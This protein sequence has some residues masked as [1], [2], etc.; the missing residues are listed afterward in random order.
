[1]V[2]LSE[3]TRII[4][5]LQQPEAYSH[6]IK[7]IKK[8]ITAVSVVFLTGEL[9]YKF[10]KPMNLGF[11]DFS[12]L[13]KRKDQCE[14]EI[15]YNSLISPSLYLGLATINQDEAGK[16]QINGSGK[17]I[18]YA[19]KM[20]QMNPDATIN[21][22][23]KKNK[24]TTN[25]ILKLAKTIHDFH[26]KASDDE[27]T[28][29]FGTLES[30]KFNWEENFQQTE[31]YK[32]FLIP[33]KTFSNIHHTVNLFLEKNKNLINQRVVKNKIKHCHGDFHSSNVFIHRGK[34][35]VF[36]GIVFNKRFPCSDIIAEIAF[37]AMDLE[38]HHQKELAATFINEYHRLS[39]DHD[40][41]KL[42]DF[43]KCYRAYIRGKIAC[44]TCDDQNL[45]AEEKEQTK[46]TAQE[47][48][49]L[50]KEYAEKL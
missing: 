30:I 25:H 8:I 45:S 31:K 48:F 10:N 50:A 27:E 49:K 24:V 36:D 3:T 16:I 34:P 17:V 41:P 6:P 20:K 38:Y 18:E 21:N 14:K 9:A 37:M 32:D 47:Y 1:M 46:Q 39:N 43:Y 22:L 11:L 7:S 44:F 35:I 40:I 15:K 33:A 42:L 26:Q 19:V 2:D 12:T 28:K 13:E 29:S 5:A 4:S 23:L